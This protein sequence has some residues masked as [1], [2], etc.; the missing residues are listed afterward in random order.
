MPAI[1][2]SFL[3]FYNQ[4]DSKTVNYFNPAQN[5]KPITVKKVKSVYGLEFHKNY[6]F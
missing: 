3:L 5:K 6:Q 1:F 4:P 2:T